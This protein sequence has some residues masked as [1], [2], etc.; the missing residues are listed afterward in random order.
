M[1]GARRKEEPRSRRQKEF[2][3]KEKLFMGFVFLVDAKTR[4]S[5]A[6]TRPKLQFQVARTK[7][8]AKVEV[9]SWMKQN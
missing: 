3:K 5:V 1:L 8:G 7:L 6:I 9:G 4:V 2:K